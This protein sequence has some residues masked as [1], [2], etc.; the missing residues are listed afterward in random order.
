MR[1]LEVA[2]R[3]PFD[4]TYVSLPERFH[5]A[6]TPAAP[7]GPELIAFNEALA[8]EL[9]VER[10]ETSDDE[11]ARLLGGNELPAGAQPIAAVYAGHQFGHPVPRLGDGR[12]ILLGEV[13]GAAGRRDLQLKGAGRTAYSRGGDGRSPLGPVLREYLVSE[14]M[15]ALGVPTTRA[16]AAVA[17]GEPVFR[18][19][20]PEPG[21]VMTRVAASHLRVGTFE[22]FARTDKDDLATLLDYALERH[23]PD[24][25]GAEDRAFAFF[26]R[27]ARRT[28]GLVAQW[29]RVGFI[30]GVM[31][32]DNTSISGETID[33]GPCAFMDTFDPA[34]VYSS[35]DRTGR[36]RFE[37]QAPIALWNLSILASCLVPLIDPED[38][39][40]A[41]ARLEEALGGYQ[42][43]WEGAWLAAMAPKLGIE[44]PEPADGELIRAFLGRFEVKGLDYTNA[45]RALPYE[46]DADEP[47]YARWRER[48]DRQGQPREEVVA[49]MNAAN[50]YL[51]PRNHQVARAIELG[52]SGDFSH[53]HALHAA[54]ARPYEERL[55]LEPFTAPPRADEV[56]HKTFCGT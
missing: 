4:N 25:A 15:H 29:W 50:P 40:R 2:L 36:Y 49:R 53:F 28:L 8:R 23:D 9:G 33:Y 56:V 43:I 42:A 17:T 41:V 44:P 24:L 45:W 54:L 21:A 34:Q 5:A 19:R 6:A 10:G 38:P 1:G 7:R 51:I 46:L 22:Y 30:H 11:L 31:N 20:G 55:E 26:E 39:D 27:V 37:N 3:I 47:L 16:L 18:E 52:E 14:A 32:T 13:V 48:L 12:A 35:I